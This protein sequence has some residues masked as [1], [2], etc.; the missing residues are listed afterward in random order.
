MFIRSINIRYITG[1]ASWGNIGGTGKSKT[2][3]KAKWI[4]SEGRT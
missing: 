1:K 4:T 2:G 3:C